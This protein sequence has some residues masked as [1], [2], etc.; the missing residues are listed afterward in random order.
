MLSRNKNGQTIITSNMNE[1]QK[2][3]AESKKTETKEYILR[4]HLLR[5]Q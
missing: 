4:F 2:H 3:N 5:E 1:T